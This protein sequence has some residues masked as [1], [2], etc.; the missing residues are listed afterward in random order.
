VIVPEGALYDASKVRDTPRPPATPLKRGSGLRAPL[1]NPLS[2]GYLPPRQLHGGMPRSG[3]VCSRQELM[4]SCIDSRGESAVALVPCKHCGT[5]F[6]PDAARTEYCCAG[7]EYVHRLITG[8][9]LDRFYQLREGATAPVRSIV[10]QPRDYRW[11][12]GLVKRAESTAATRGGDATLDLDLQ[13]ISCVGC[14]WLVDRIFRERPGARGIRI[15]ATLGRMSLRWEPGACDVAAFARELQRFGYLV[16][17]MTKTARSESGSLVLR[18]GVCAAFAMN[19]MLFSVPRYLGMEPDFPYAWLFDLL[20]FVF[21]SASVVVGGTYF[22]GRT[23]RSLRLGVLHIDLPI[24]LGILV[25]YAGSI[26]AWSKASGGFLYFDFVSTFTFLMIVGR[27]TQ[28]AAVERNRNQLLGLRQDLPPVELIEDDPAGGGHRS[29]A[30]KPAEA[31][32]RG[33]RFLVGT[34]QIVPVSST[35]LGPAGSIGLDW[36]SGESEARVVAPGQVVESGAIN[37]SPHPL[38][39]EAL[40]PWATSLLSRLLAVQP[41]SEWRNRALEQVIRIYLLAVLVVGFVGGAA[42]L[43]VTREVTPALQVLVSVLVVSCPCAL[44]VT[45]PLIDEIAVARLRHAGVFVKAETLWARLSRVRKVIFDKT[46]T[47]TLESLALR[48]PEALQALAPEARAALWVLVRTSR[49]PVSVCLRE[50]MMAGGFDCSEGEAITAA[51]VGDLGS[52][53]H[54]GQPQAD[55]HEEVGH[56]LEWRDADGRIWRLGKEGW[57]DQVGAASAAIVRPP[58]IEVAAE[59]APTGNA[60]VVLGR[61]GVRLAAFSTSEEVREDAATEIA[62]L[63]RTGR[64]VFILS[65]DRL[66]KVA[67]MATKLGLPPDSA[68][69]GMTPEAKAEWVRRLDHADTLMIGDGVND[70]LAF[71]AAACRGTPAV[72]RGVLEHRADFYFLGRGV[73]G[74]RRLLDAAGVRSATIRRVI[75]FAI[76]YNAVVVAVALA[77]RMSPVLAA[78]LMPLS[79]VASLAIAVTGMRRV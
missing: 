3:G 70:S 30:T 65:G 76:G 28:L 38:R 20:A 13:G 34:G 62:R 18:L 12:E 47:L 49:H 4:T 55:V 71:D 51:A 6:R 16:G 45:L 53:R 61:D 19:N 40:E 44:G 26:Y 41:P 36:V 39:L 54:R 46:G 58:A 79:A 27:W 66:E 50:A 43:L 60:D 22:F 78:V 74:I 35:L 10:F 2:R 77:G 24:S 59:A 52:R 7:C 14:V 57:A 23:W 73:G 9:K 63:R 25:G 11:L 8:Q 21:A 64:K 31:L 68:A 17:P 72:E 32:D 15:N 56:G 67:A 1:R 29:V 75:A 42:W 33:E 5:P 37:L 69:A 48:N